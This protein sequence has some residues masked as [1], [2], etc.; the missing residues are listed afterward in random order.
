M[1]PDLVSLP[2]FPRISALI[3]EAKYKKMSSIGR[4]SVSRKREYIWTRACSPGMKEQ[5]EEKKILGSLGT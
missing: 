4:R 2:T 1:T 5:E 3:A